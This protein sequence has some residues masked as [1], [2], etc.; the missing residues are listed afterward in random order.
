MKQLL[1]F[2]ESR[3]VAM[4]DELAALA[5]LESPSGDRAAIARL[6]AALAG[7]LGELG[8]QAEV[9]DAPGSV[10][11]LRARF[12]SERGERPVLLLGHLDTVWPVGEIETM[13]VRLEGRRFHGPGV[14]DMK[15]GLVLALEAIRALGAAGPSGMPPVS[16]LFTGDEEV[17]SRA[18]RGLIEETARSSAA[19]LVLEPALPGGAV[20][21]SRKGCGEYELTVR[22]VAAHAGIEPEKGSS[23]ILELAEQLLAVE[24]LQDAAKGTTLSAGVIS[25]GTRPNVVPAAARATIDARASSLEESRRVDAALRGLHPRRAR[26]LLEWTGG[27]DRPPFERT[28]AVARL[29]AI[30]RGI[31]AELGF[32]LGEGATGGGSDGNFTAALGVPTLDGLGAEGDGAHA[33]HEHVLVD[34]LAP[35]AALLAGLLARIG[36]TIGGV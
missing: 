16:V 12:G 1:A 28:E 3:A 10:P 33:A 17:G 35:R 7:R 19:V 20:K 9:F 24:R 32:E 21:T 31:A 34:R 26:T 27:F 22:G 23:A 30:A 11:C 6:A 18:S 13:P 15:G 2:C 29:F 8:G 25:G 36:G 14:F 5:R 4:R